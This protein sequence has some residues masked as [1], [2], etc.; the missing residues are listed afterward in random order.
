MPQYEATITAS[1]RSTESFQQ[2]ESWLSRCV[3][4][5]STCKDAF[6]QSSFVPTRLIQIMRRGEDDFAIRL[7]DGKSLNATLKYATLS[8]CW[9]NSMPYKLTKQ[10]LDSCMQ[11]VSIEKLSKVFQD[12][13]YVAAR[14]DVWYIWIDSLCECCGA[15]SR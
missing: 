13:I 10:N 7:R 11:K 1:N 15:G 6:P 5:H 4:N 9:G 2:M 12:A 3:L 14:C 8:H